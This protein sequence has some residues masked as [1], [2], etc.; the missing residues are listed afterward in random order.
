MRGFSLVLIVQLLKKILLRFDGLHY[1]Q[2]YL[3]LGKESFSHPL[4]VYL[5]HQGRPVKDIT[6]LHCFIGYSPLVFAIDQA[7][8]GTG[9][10]IIE[11]IFSQ[12]P[13]PL[14][15]PFPANSALAF[16]RMEKTGS[17]RSVE[18]FEGKKAKHRFIN[19]FHRAIGNL[20]NHSFNRKPGNVFL[21]KELY[22]QVQVAYSVPR[23]IS[24]VTV[25]KDDFYNLFPT[26]L[27]GQPGEGL[28]II[29]LRHEGFA[30]K[31]V[32][33][34]GKIVLSEM[35]AKAYKTVYSLGKNHM[36]P[37]KPASV[38]PFSSLVSDSFRL[39]LPEGALAYKELEL[40]HSFNHGIHKIMVFRIV[41]QAKLA[42][43]AAA[44][45]KGISEQEPE[46]LVH[47][48]KVYATWR[49]KNGFRS[50]YLLR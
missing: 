5:L 48:H 28:Y 14:E 26:D 46:S 24:Q 12:Q 3:C 34:S 38:F 11:L 43:K 45:M 4:R 17:Y 41:N 13:L 8:L 39:P 19:A 23:K 40:E 21:G 6:N 25:G 44:P 35:Q 50:N 30:S 20:I 10:E 37:L 29:S 1:R 49:D 7:V 18:F 42:L 2:E 31:Q 15:K 16:L 36:Q 9:R 33:Q 47:I 27:H 32:I 22:K